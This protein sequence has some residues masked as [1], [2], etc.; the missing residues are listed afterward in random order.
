[1]RTKQ[2]GLF[3]CVRQEMGRN[4]GMPKT[5]NIEMLIRGYDIVAVRTPGHSSAL[6]SCMQGVLGSVRFEV[7]AYG[8]MRSTFSIDV[9]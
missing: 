1:M 8:Q 7:P 9:P 3:S 4:P 6:E 5:V 2:G